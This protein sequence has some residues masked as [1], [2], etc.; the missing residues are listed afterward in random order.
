M[1]TGELPTFF[2]D[3]FEHPQGSLKLVEILGQNTKEIGPSFSINFD[4]AVTF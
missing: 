4:L 1:A 2:L 3:K